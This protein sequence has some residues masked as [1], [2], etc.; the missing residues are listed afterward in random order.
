[1]L[2]HLS[3]TICEVGMVRRATYQGCW[4][5]VRWMPVPGTQQG[6][7]VKPSQHPASHMVLGPSSWAFGM[8]T[9][10]KTKGV[11]STVGIFQSWLGV[12]AQAPVN[13]PGRL[14]SRSVTPMCAE[15]P[16]GNSL[17]SLSLSL[18]NITDGRTSSYMMVDVYSVVVLNHCLPLPPK[19]SRRYRPGHSPSSHCPPN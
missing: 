5:Q 16:G 19:G 1:M 6:C 12:I 11:Q 13:R 7:S 17:T 2:P 3:L 15:F 18:L 9:L 10:Q 4:C 8:F 14:M